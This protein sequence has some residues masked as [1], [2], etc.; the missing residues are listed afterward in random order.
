[1]ATPGHREISLSS[2][3][4]RARIDPF[5]AQLSVLQD[6]AGRD[7]LWSGDPAV[8]KGRA[9]ILFPIVGALAGGQYRLDGRTHSLPRHGFA[10]DSLFETIQADRTRALLRLRAS[11][12]TRAVYPFDFE[13]DV[14]FEIDEASL[15]V[16]TV[17]R[18]TGAL[19]LPASH[20]YHPAFR[21]PLPYGADRASHV[22]EFEQ[23]ECGHI[24]RL[25]ANG[26]L[27]PELHATPLA[28]RYLRLTDQLFT[29]D[30]VIFDQLRSHRV[31]YGTAA[32]P[33]IELSLGDAPYLGIW[34]RPGSG[35]I[36]IEPWHG[37]ADPQAFSGDFTAKPGVFTVAEGTSRSID[38]RITLMNHEGGSR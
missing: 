32:A 34:T 3:A 27:T 37:I 1:M 13:L 9:P 4:L 15:S 24:R 29:D 17:I 12:A 25:D 16:I 35:F 36:C 11:D 23:P 7:L 28:G 31:R 21:W 19:P 20:G 5:G 38:M 30:A 18:N 22:I 2:A 26:L 14:R 6:G 33:R 10:R 8:W